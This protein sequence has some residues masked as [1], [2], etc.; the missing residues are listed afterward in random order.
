M[1]CATEIGFQSCF[2][3]VLP[4]ESLQH[5]STQQSP[6]QVILTVD[7]VTCHRSGIVYSSLARIIRGFVLGD[8]D[9]LIKTQML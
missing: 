1:Y 3:F 4:L 9:F 5:S 7:S 8:R 6:S 2:L